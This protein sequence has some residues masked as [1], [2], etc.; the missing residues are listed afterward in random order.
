VV[1]QT[2]T[3]EGT[4]S[5]EIYP[6]VSRE[7]SRSAGVGPPVLDGPGGIPQPTSAVPTPGSIHEGGERAR[8]TR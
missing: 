4:Y 7:R 1:A 3:W 6:H 8:L 5:G 2:S